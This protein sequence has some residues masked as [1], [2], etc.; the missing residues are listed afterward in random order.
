MYAT[1]STVTLCVVG[2]ILVVCY[3]ASASKPAEIA[4]GEEPEKRIVG[5]TV[6]LDKQEA[7]PGETVR[8]TE[9]L[10]ATDDIVVFGRGH[11]ALRIGDYDG[12]LGRMVNR[13][14]DQFLHTVIG[15]A[16]DGLPSAEAGTGTREFTV[17]NP[18][19]QGFE[20]EFKPKL[21]GIWMITANWHIKGGGDGGTFIY[22]QPVILVV[23]P[24]LDAKGRPIVKDEWLPK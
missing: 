24:P 21:L 8:V 9:V 1:K 23:K 13:E 22:G 15:K 18:R 14:S 20:I 2:I 17:K 5:V 6:R 10:P 11:T 16:F 12:E 19:E 4:G 3:A 7:C